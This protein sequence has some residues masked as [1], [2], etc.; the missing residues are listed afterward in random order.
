MELRET[1]VGRAQ[2]VANG[3]I[4]GSVPELGGV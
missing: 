4:E 3:S 2:E 1:L